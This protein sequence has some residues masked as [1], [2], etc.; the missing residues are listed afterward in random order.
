LDAVYGNLC[1]ICNEETDPKGKAVQLPC[2]HIFHPA[3][4]R[5]W[6]QIKQFCPN[7]RVAIKADS[8]IELEE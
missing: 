4:I 5:K 6:L 7:C 2:K 8:F 1:S 3:C